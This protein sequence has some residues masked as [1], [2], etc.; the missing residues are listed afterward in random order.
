LVPPPRPPNC[1]A[2]RGGRN[3]RPP[4]VF[5]RPDGSLVVDDGKNTRARSPWAPGGVRGFFRAPSKPRKVSHVPTVPAIVPSYLRRRRI[6]RF[7][8]ELL[9]EWAPG[10]MV[11]RL[12]P[13]VRSKRSPHPVRARRTPGEPGSPPQ[14][15][16]VGPGR[17]GN[18]CRR[19][20]PPDRDSW[21]THPGP[22]PKPR[23]PP[24]AVVAA[25]TRLF[26]STVGASSCGMDRTPSHHA[27]ALRSPSL[28]RMPRNAFAGSAGGV[29]QNQPPARIGAPLENER[30][31]PS[32]PAFSPPGPHPCPPNLSNSPRWAAAG[33][34]FPGRTPLGP[35]A[36][37]ENRRRAPVASQPLTA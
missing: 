18:R 9:P 16:P 5:L 25:T 35:G 21:D 19:R 22:R 29:A 31:F 12:I 7:S 30:L 24:R 37:V 4:P 15:R 2:V 33:T 23:P 28:A 17:R 20:L 11:N 26:F 1:R 10:R 8:T 3:G 14:R 27:P 34:G 13:G 32:G 36:R 6:P